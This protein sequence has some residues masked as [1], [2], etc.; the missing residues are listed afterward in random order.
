VIFFLVPYDSH[1]KQWIC[2]TQHFLVG[3]C[4][5][6]WVCLLWD[7]SW[8]CTAVPTAT[9][10]P[11]ASYGTLNKLTPSTRLQMP[12]VDAIKLLWIQAPETHPPY[13]LP[14][15]SQP[16][17]DKCS[18]KQNPIYSHRVSLSQTQW[19]RQRTRMAKGT[20]T[21]VF[22]KFRLLTLCLVC[23][24]DCP[25]KETVLFFTTLEVQCPGIYGGLARPRW[26]TKEE[27]TF[28]PPSSH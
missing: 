16:R 9:M 2:P 4:N 17:Q 6:N 21:W 24:C 11:T 20:L 12:S 26:S 22:C 7:R 1:T 5:G 13:L 14:S 18:C 28:W 23:W 25:D 3:L 8:F 15:S 19:C 27:A 10:C